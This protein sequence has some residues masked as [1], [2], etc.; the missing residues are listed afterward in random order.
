MDS[1]DACLRD[2]LQLGPTPNAPA[3]GRDFVRQ[4]CEYWQ[5]ALPDVSVTE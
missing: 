3:A 2:E 1:W 5:L 4:V